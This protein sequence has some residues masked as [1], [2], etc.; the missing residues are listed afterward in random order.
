MFKSEMRLSHRSYFQWVAMLIL[1]SVWDA[2]QMKKIIW[3]KI[4]LLSGKTKNF[5]PWTKIA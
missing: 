1:E 3:N 4:W 2:Y 5:K